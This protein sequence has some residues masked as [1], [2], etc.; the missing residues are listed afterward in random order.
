MG[1]RHRLAA[2][3]APFVAA[4]AVTLVPLAG[5]AGE[6]PPDAG[7]SAE[8]TA[9]ASEAAAPEPEAPKPSA[10]A[11]LVRSETPERAV[12]KPAGPFDG[13][14]ELW[15]TLGVTLGGVVAGSALALLSLTSNAG[16]G[17]WVVL[18]VGGG[19]L[20]AASIMIG[21]SIP[22]FRIHNNAQ[23]AW[24]LVGRT[25]LTGGAVSFFLLG[26]MTGAV[27]MP[28]SCD[29]E[30]EDCDDGDD[31][32]QEDTERFGIGF[33]VA[34]EALALA[35]AII[36]LATLPRAVERA[37]EKAASKRISNVTL[38]PVVAPGPNGSTAA[39]LAF[40]MRF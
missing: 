29:Y 8:E 23:G 4:A 13:D 1:E 15:I 34:F 37:N 21:P 17:P 16:D 26:A 12:P 2:R 31:D 10:P 18:V 22:H 7:I 3:A 14:K 20:A 30:L 40:A 19:G 35:W 27:A 32:A 33:G 39:G 36:D 9:A 5:A 6:E 28:G 24:G 11:A 25:L 38:S